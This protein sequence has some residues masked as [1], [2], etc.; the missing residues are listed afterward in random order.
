[1]DHPAVAQVHDGGI[2]DEGQPFLVLEL[3]ENARSLD[4][5]ADEE[6][7]ALR[8]RVELL[9]AAARGV[10]HAHGRGVIHRDLKPSNLLV[11]RDGA[12]GEARVKIID[13]GIARATEQILTEATLVTAAGEVLGTPDY[14]SPE[15]AQSG[16]REVDVR[17]DVYALGAILYQ[18]V[19]GKPP[20]DLAGR[21]LSL[22]EALDV[23]RHEVPLK[24]SVDRDLSLIVAKAMEK[25][26]E[27]R[28]AGAGALAEDLERWL[29][30][31]P[32]VARAPSF[33]YLAGKWVRRHKLAAAAV[34]LALVALAGGT[35]VSTVLAVRAREAQREAVVASAQSDFQRAADLHA[36][37][38]MDEAVAFLSRGLRRQGDDAAAQ[39]LLLHILTHTHFPRPLAVARLD[40]GGGIDY[41][42]VPSAGGE[43][44]T[45]VSEWTHFQSFD[46]RTLEPRHEWVRVGNER[47]GAA[48]VA[49]DRE[50]AVAVFSTPEGN[51]VRFYSVAD[52]RESRE[53]IGIEDGVGF[54]AASG[55]GRRLLAGPEGRV[56]FFEL[57]D[58]AARR[59]G[60]MEVPG[61]GRGQA[62][63]SHDGSLAAFATRNGFGGVYGV[64]D[65]EEKWRTNVE[66]AGMVVA[67][68][69][70]ASSVVVGT[71]A[72]RRAL[73]G[74]FLCQPLTKDGRPAGAAREVATGGPVSGLHFHHGGSGL[75]AVPEYESGAVLF[76]P[77][78]GVQ[79]GRTPV[80]H[81]TGID[82]GAVTK[83]GSHVFTADR[84]GTVRGWLWGRE[85]PGLGPLRLAAGITDLHVSADGGRLITADAGGTLMI[86]DLRHSAAVAPMLQLGSRPVMVM[87]DGTGEMVACADAAGRFHLWR[88][89]EVRPFFSL[90][91]GGPEDV[92]AFDWASGV[93]AVGGVGE[94]VTIYQIEGTG[95]AERLAEVAVKGRVWTLAVSG[96][97]G[98]GFGTST[99]QA[100]M[101]RGPQWE[102]KGPVELGRWITAGAWSRD[103]STFAAGTFRPGTVRV[104]RDGKESGDLGEVP[105]P[106][107]ALA[108]SPDGG[109]VAALA[110]SGQVYVGEGDGDLL[111]RFSHEAPVPRL[112][113]FAEF[114]PDGR[115]LL[116]GG[117]RDQRAMVW[118][119]SGSGDE[120]VWS[121]KR[122]R[123]MH[124]A[125]VLSP[126]GRL[127]AGLNE[128]DWA[129][130]RSGRP[131][132][133]GRVERGA[134]HA[135]CAGFSGDGRVLA[136]G[137]PDGSVHVV[138]APVLVEE[139]V[140]GW[141]ADFAE[142][143]VGLRVGAGGRVEQIPGARRMEYLAGFSVRV[144]D[145]TEA[146]ET[147]RWLLEDPGTRAA[148]PGARLGTAEV[149]KQLAPQAVASAQR[150]LLLHRPGDAAASLALAR[151]VMREDSFTGHRDT[152]A[153]LARH[154]QKTG[155]LW[156]RWEATRFLRSLN[157]AVAPLE[158]APDAR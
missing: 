149:L 46:A 94:R 27:R 63:M 153:S 66:A 20:H 14:L 18:L 132:G 79:T 92:F 13:F 42:I 95:R 21:G 77:A 25:E 56:E 83:N 111:E 35:V 101:L 141:L 99:G 117:C 69:P 156:V 62:A 37:G 89:G 146:A 144:G 33:F 28:Y 51:G 116:T 8:G 115:G 60:G 71:A 5:W 47:R 32:V 140:P 155:P 105:T 157:M 100:G 10:E 41:R 67:F 12:S 82:R 131:L 108:V 34:V 39:S 49:G 88:I 133:R 3:L 106:I 125:L 136:V 86:A 97:G 1:L 23:I 98:V 109:R 128:L 16:G 6:G 114:F 142:Q 90:K 138:P 43:S 110:E 4:G 15:Q 112:F 80:G 113:G 87:P 122:K 154:A 78:S 152:A 17:T 148:W 118:D 158:S 134:E 24:L 54:F 68:A 139:E 59:I 135:Q 107:R 61:G 104:W 72:G 123:Y 147:V 137:Y 36:E 150:T 119:V 52:G 19:S 73:E 65:S 2:S 129:E 120:A 151:L 102:V 124:T 58:G 44:L 96:Q 64:A 121:G 57:G 55:D 38:R 7:V 50:I 22:V 76:H 45:A 143:W 31:E 53:R 127:V 9:L 74:K 70:D 84:E 85:S 91:A 81:R 29:R 11:W 40:Q 75:L 30:G 126:D 130:A 48:L 93:L 103:G 145:G 26:R